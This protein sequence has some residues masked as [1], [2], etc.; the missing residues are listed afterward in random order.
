[1]SHFTRSLIRPAILPLLL[2]G[3]IH[4]KSVGDENKYTY[5]L[6]NARPHNQLLIDF[7]RLRLA[8][9][10]QFEGVRE[11]SGVD[12]RRSRLL[13]RWRASR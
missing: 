10:Y 7:I 5:S 9:N 8:F 1:M 4:I 11:K 12:S 3:Q 6:V 2:P 13:R